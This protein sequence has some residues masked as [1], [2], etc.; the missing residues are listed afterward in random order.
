MKRLSA[1]IVVVGAGPAGM[2]A[3]VSAAECG[4]RVL[5]LDDNPAPGG[6]IWRNQ[7]VSG[8]PAARTWMQRVQAAKVILE[9]DIRV[10]GAQRD[11]TLLAERAREA[12]VVQFSRLV[13]ATGARELLLPFP[14][15][16]L[17]GVA[18]A[19]GLQALVQGGLP[20]DGKRVVV[21]GS[22]PLL[23][24]VAAHLRERGAAVQAIIE[25]AS[26][27]K[28]ARF[29]L[30]LG[31]AKLMQAARFAGKCRGVP[32]LYSAWPTAAQGRGR[33]ESVPV[34]TARG[35][36]AFACDYLACGFGLVPN[37]ELA[38]LLG[39]KLREGF[40]AVDDQQRTSVE[41][42]FCAG[43]PT[44][45]AGLDGSLIEGQIAGYAAAGRRT[46]ELTAKR[47]RSRTFGE[48]MA[49]AFALRNELKQICTPETVV[50][51]CEDVSL[52]Q[53][54]AYGEWKGAKLQTRCGMG[55]CQ[56]R[57]CG[58]AIAFLSGGRTRFESVRP[59][60][61][62]ASMDTLATDPAAEDQLV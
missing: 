62:P 54:S 7:T 18:G 15:W 41:G 50:C 60:L 16:T 40:V 8:D 9:A 61:F 38:Q 12:Y 35:V 28:V 29:G 36:R 52:R 19:G 47:N 31:L 51:R 30:G 24:A 4:G 20:I 58:P 48:R 3:A 43:E 49:R 37:T 42:V 56:G 10:L 57:M 46:T 23:L 21:A 45:I 34:Q 33:L 17:P 59:P 39:C 32:I 26:F 44:G 5:L 6:Q 1:D 22:G 27:G 2:A 55:P 53:I 14:G 25:Q 13:L 11:R